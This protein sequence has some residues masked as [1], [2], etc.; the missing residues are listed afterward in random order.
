MNK[1]KNFLSNHWTIIASLG[2][3]VLVGL[4][5]PRAAHAI[6]PFGDIYFKL[7]VMCCTVMLP[8]IIATSIGKIV[9]ARDSRGFLARIFGGLLLTFVSVSA[10]GIGAAFLAA[11]ITAPTFETER[12]MG[13]LMVNASTH[14]PGDAPDALKNYYFVRELDTEKVAAK[15]RTGFGEV[16][17]D[18][19]PDNIFDALANRKTVQVMIF[20]MIFGL[21]FNGM[22]PGVAT[23][24]LRLGESLFEAFNVM[25]TLL[26]YALPFGIIALIANETIGL[27]FDIL[28]PL[29]KLAELLALLFLALAGVC[30]LVIR[31]A[32]RRPWS[33]IFRALQEPLILSFVAENLVAMPSLIRAMTD[34]LGFDRNRT[35]CAVP[36]WMGMEIHAD[37]A[38]FAAA[39]IFTMQ[40]Y[41]V[42]VGPT[43]LVIVLCGSVIAGLSAMAAAAV[44]WVAL[45]KNVLDPLGIPS[46]PIIFALM[47]FEPFF[48]GLLF[49]LNALVSCA[50]VSIVAGR[51]RSVGGKGCATGV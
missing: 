14:T 45:I 5:A 24:L 36:L 25:L 35:G 9:V 33:Q 1:L 15:K 47:L 10:L 34:K 20:S 4:E 39:S 21:L 27:D 48:N 41:H 37:V 19:F 2:V 12:A 11:P 38:V 49:L 28:L 43:E 22:P 42:P 17:A 30:L 6:K 31:V 7:I 26:I 18:F 50:A 3:G 40:L 44:L 16:M 13:K 23:S 32:S 51:E 46:A 29:L 8:V